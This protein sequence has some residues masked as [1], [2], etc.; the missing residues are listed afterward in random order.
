MEIVKKHKLFIIITSII[1][2]LPIV[3]GVVL[4]D[5]LP[6]EMATH[7]GSDGTPNDWSPR[8][9]TVFGLPIFLLAVHLICV[10]ATVSGPQSKGINSTVFKIVG[11][12]VPV[13]SII[14]AVGI[15][16]YELGF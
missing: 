3:V 9:F 11:L 12:I 14:C 4:W 2:L 10:F 16:G 8:G 7:F 15:Y 1:T 6:W 5:K 13:C